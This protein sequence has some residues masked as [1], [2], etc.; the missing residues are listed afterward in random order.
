MKLEFKDPYLEKL[1]ENRVLVICEINQ[2]SGYPD[3]T[4]IKVLIKNHED[5]TFIPSQNP[6][7]KIPKLDNNEIIVTW[8]LKIPITDTPIEIIFLC[9]Q[10][11]MISK[12]EICSD[13]WN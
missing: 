8:I 12:I 4:N 1:D 10:L 11:E 6:E 9:D 7:I 2:L 5:F 3:F 13:K